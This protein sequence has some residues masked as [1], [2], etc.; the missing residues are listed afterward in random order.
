MIP[1][2]F[3]T[4]TAVSLSFGMAQAHAAAHQCQ[5]ARTKG[6]AAVASYYNPRVGQL[7]EMATKGVKLTD[8]KVK[9]PHIDGQEQWMTLAELKD[10]LS[11]EK[12]RA[13]TEVTRAINDCERGFKPYQDVMNN[14][15]LVATGGLSKLLPER[16]TRIDVSDIL[17]GY[18]LGGPDAFVPKLREQILGGDRGTVANIVRDPWKCITFQRKC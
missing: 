3:F 5:E 8:V 17:A 11:A 7:D 13:A 1:K 15:V 16:A 2:T 9:V 6:E 18:P 10:R 12:V 14:F 4:A